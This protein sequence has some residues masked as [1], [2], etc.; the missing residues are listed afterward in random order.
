MRNFRQRVGREAIDFSC[1]QIGAFGRGSTAISVGLKRAKRAATSASSALFLW[2][3]DVVRFH[4]VQILAG[5]SEMIRANHHHLR[6]RAARRSL[7]ER[8]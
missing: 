8:D 5:I 7:S 4:I 3:E 1:R 2:R 6:R